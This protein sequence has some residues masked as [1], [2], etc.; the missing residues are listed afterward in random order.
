MPEETCQINTSISSA[1]KFDYS[2]LFFFLHFRLLLMCRILAFHALQHISLQMPLGRELESSD[3]MCHFHFRFIHARFLFLSL[4]TTS[5]IPP[6]TRHLITKINFQMPCHK[7]FQ[8]IFR[9][10]FLVQ[11]HKSFVYT[12]ILSMSLCI[13]NSE[14][15]KKLDR[16]E[17]NSPCSNWIPTV[18]YDWKQN[19]EQEIEFL[20][21]FPID[22]HALI[23]CLNE[24][25]MYF[26]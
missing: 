8:P 10:D 20:F 22:R 6:P 21:K 11:H 18:E 17:K 7:D 2:D 3:A 23:G 5:L 25:K 16:N 14:E 13:F 24:K 4:N 12:I 15:G 9:L 1:H 26:C 19:Q